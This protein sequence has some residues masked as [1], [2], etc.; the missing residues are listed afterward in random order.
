M[1]TIDQGSAPALADPFLARA[2]T[3]EWRRQHGRTDF[4]IELAMCQT[5]SVRELVEGEQPPVC[6]ANRAI[7]LTGLFSRGGL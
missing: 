6:S 4:F 2:A 7:R 1:L 5:G 3:R